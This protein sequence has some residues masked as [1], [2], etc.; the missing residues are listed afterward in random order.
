MSDLKNRLDRELATVLP[1]ADARAAMDRRVARRRRRRTILLPAAT[2]ILTAGL[3]A[4][5]TY[6]FSDSHRPPGDSR[7][8]AMPGEALEAMVDGDV[9]WVL[10]SERGCE[11]PVCDGS[12][13]KVDAIRG[14]V[15]DRVPVTTPNGIAAGAGSIW[16]VS[17]ADDTLLR[18]EPATGSIQATIP[19]VL[20]F[21][22]GND[23]D[24][25]FLPV[26]VDAND[27]AV[28]VSSGRGALAHIDPATNDVVDI[29]PRRSHTGGPVAIS[30]EGI[31]VA[32]SLNGAVLVDP[33][34]HRVVDAV[35]LDDEIG[36]RFSVNTLL[37]RDGSVWAVGNW[38]RPVEELGGA[39]YVAGEGHAVV[40]INE[41]SREVES[42]LDIRDG[43]A[44]LLEGDDLWVVEHD[45]AYLRRI[46][47]VRRTLDRSVDVPF[48]RP[49][50][51][52]GGVAWSAVGERLQRW[53]LPVKG[54][55][56]VSTGADA[57]ERP[58]VEPA[59]L[60]W[61]DSGATMPDP[62][63]D[64]IHRRVTWQG[65]PATQ[66]AGSYVSVRVL[67]DVASPGTEP[68]PS[69]PDGTAGTLRLHL[70]EWAALWQFST[71]Y[72]GSIALY[73]FVPGAP[74]EQARSIAVEIA[75]S[76]TERTDAPT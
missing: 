76:M 39:G 24:R 44:W 37:A 4:G 16:V 9:L 35:T 30:Q 47:P 67:M 32:E 50:A 66:W 46:D 36:Q 11:G 74:P 22:V 17:F 33:A 62:V 13:V 72:C 29:V 25:S 51:V 49:L 59:T 58:L 48:G 73:V 21:T 52:S 53:E 61:L 20:P 10:T 31:W 41:R 28:W 42:I 55:D 38:A 56:S 45:G 40:E 1:R 23:G 7:A 3:V 5:L 26:D 43:A 60:P 14:E 34:T 12:V 2:L 65:P 70:R 68:A 64:S 19:L 69:L 71:R 75:R 54:R 57:C 63:A 18:L 27:E 15:V 6:A 8:I